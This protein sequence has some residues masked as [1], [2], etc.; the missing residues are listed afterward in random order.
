MHEAAESIPHVFW[1]Q[2]WC[3]YNAWELCEIQIK[4]SPLS[5]RLRGDINSPEKSHLFNQVRICFK[6]RRRQYTLQKM[7]H[8]GTL[9]YHFLSVFLSCNGQ[10]FA[11]EMMMVRKWKTCQP[12]VLFV[13]S[14]SLDVNKLKMVLIECAN[15]KKWKKRSC[16]GL[17]IISHSLGKNNKKIAGVNYGNTNCAIFMSCVWIKYFYINNEI[18]A[19]NL[20]FLIFHT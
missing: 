6:C 12:I 20:K 17:Y 5:L 11:L 3:T 10:P 7:N 1:S 8:L 18:H 4:V 13:F 14:P 15:V 2:F 9:S 19:N 16:L